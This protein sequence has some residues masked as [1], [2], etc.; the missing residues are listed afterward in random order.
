M[1]SVVHGLPHSVHTTLYMVGPPVEFISKRR[2]RQVGWQWELKAGT[3]NLSC[4]V[5]AATV[6]GMT[7]TWTTPGY[8]C[9]LGNKY[10]I[11]HIDFSKEN[12]IKCAPLA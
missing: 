3:Q 8:E 11:W 4:A 12:R 1:P 9:V 7:I 10:H 6:S 5:D 2:F